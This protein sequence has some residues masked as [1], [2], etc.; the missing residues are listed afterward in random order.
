MENNLGLKIR[1]LLK[2]KRVSQK[3]LSQ[4]IS[5]SQTGLQGILKNNSTSVKTLNNIANYF[6]VPIEYFLNE[7]DN[8]NNI[9]NSINIGKNNVTG[10]IKGHNNNLHVTLDQC[11]HEV[12]LLKDR[13]KDKDVVIQSLKE[14]IKLLNKNK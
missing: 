3:E 7:I 11:R 5:I 9:S 1:E 10:N 14:Q 2:L 8:K 13:L 6:N 4:A 12:E